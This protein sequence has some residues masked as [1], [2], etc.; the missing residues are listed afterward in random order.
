MARI[1]TL[2]GYAKSV[3]ALGSSPEVH[4]TISALLT[5]LTEQPDV[6]AVLRKHRP[7]RVIRASSAEGF[8]PLRMVYRHVGDAVFVFHVLWYDELAYKQ[9]GVE[10]G[11]A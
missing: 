4:N 6:G 8:C 3:A 2:A 11:Q 10:R 5:R 7:V 1:V 9:R